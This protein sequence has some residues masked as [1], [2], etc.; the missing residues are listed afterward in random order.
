MPHRPKMRS[1]LALTVTQPNIMSISILYVRIST[2]DQKTDRQRMSESDFDKVIEDKCSGSIPM[3]ERE[4]GKELKRLC[5]LGVVNKISCWQ[6]DRCGRDL[7]DILNFIHYTTEKKIPVHFISQ[8]LKTFDENGKEDGIA[9]ATIS[10]L[11]IVANMEKRLILERQKEGIYLAKL[12]G[13]V[14]LGRKPNTKEDP[15]RFL[16]KPKNKKAMDLIKKGYKAREVARIIEI[17]PNTVTKVKKL[18]K[19]IA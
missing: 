8:G 16:S 12:K 4:G 17:S 2:L 5:D 3:F 1:I 9:M 7:R 18:M 10:I 19:V 14:F 15:L 11:G 13:N 6:I